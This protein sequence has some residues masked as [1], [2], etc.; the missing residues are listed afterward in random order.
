MA[1]PSILLGLPMVDSARFRRL[2]HQCA[3][4]FAMTCS[5]LVP[6]P[7]VCLHRGGRKPTALRW[8]HLKK[9]TSLRG[10]KRRGNPLDFAEITNGRFR[11]ISG[12]AT[13]LRPSQ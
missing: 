10:A 7:H 9:N 3:H 13:G 11:S 12:I 5:L 6:F 2:P 8:Q 4:W 1:I